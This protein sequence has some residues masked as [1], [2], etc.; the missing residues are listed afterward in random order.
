MIS[1]KTARKQKKKLRDL[2]ED[3]QKSLKKQGIVS[4]YKGE[5]PRTRKAKHKHEK[6]EL[7]PLWFDDK[8]GVALNDGNLYSVREVF[9]PDKQENIVTKKFVVHLP[10]EITKISRRDGDYIVDFK[11]ISAEDSKPLDDFISFVS[12]RAK[13]TGRTRELFAGYINSYI[14]AEKKAKRINIEELPIMID[15]DGVIR[16]TY[17]LEP[18]LSHI[19][20]EEILRSLVKFRQHAS[21]PH[22]FDSA[23]SFALTAPLHYELRKRTPA[24]TAIPI[25]VSFGATSTGKTSISSFFAVEGYDQS[26]DNAIISLQSVR[27]RFTWLHMLAQGTLPVV[28]DDMKIEWIDD[29]SEELKNISNSSMAGVRGRQDQTVKSYSARRAIFITLNDVVIRSENAALARRSILEEYT[30]EIKQ[31][32]DPVAFDNVRAELPRGFMFF[33][34]KEV[35][36][37]KNIDN[38][39]EEVRKCRSPTDFVNYGLSKINELCRLFDLP[40]FLKYQDAAQ[41]DGSPGQ[42]MCEFFLVQWNRI[43]NVDENGRVRPPYPDLDRDQIDVDTI[44]PGVYSIFFTAAAYSYARSRLKL[45]FMTARDLLNNVVNDDRI[46]IGAYKTHRFQ[47][48]TLK[49]FNVRFWTGGTL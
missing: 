23:L 18:M 25:H 19:G 5:R 40:E 17:N 7:T 22:A 2:P 45:K 9:D 41:S 48:T 36:D 44:E 34:F 32:L 14:A 12:G 43:N 1:D 49:A 13:L 42:L 30:P 46:A 16:V 27:T 37:G 11:W 33:I 8:H 6:L 24:D 47:N 3:L 28:L 31:K 26:K 39:V 20:V 29:L 38:V 21:N 15:G 10:L 35:F 4:D